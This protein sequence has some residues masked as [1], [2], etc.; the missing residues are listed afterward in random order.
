MTNFEANGVTD[1]GDE[2]FYGCGGQQSGNTTIN[3]ASTETGNLTIGKEAFCF[4]QGLKEVNLTAKTISI[5]VDAFNNSYFLN[6]L[7]LNGEVTSVGEGALSGPGSR[8]ILTIYYNLGE[9]AFAKVCP[10]GQISNSGLE[11]GDYIFK[12]TS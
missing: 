1:I 6:S 9:D 5:G 10:D 11:E 7:T 2:A 12:T 3:I 8:L 4:A